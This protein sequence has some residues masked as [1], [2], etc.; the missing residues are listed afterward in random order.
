MTRPA[1]PAAAPTHLLSRP[2]ATLAA[3]VGALVGGL[4]GATGL[5]VVAGL[6]GGAV[7]GL[8]ALVTAVASVGAVRVLTAGARR[9]RYQ[10]RLA[11]RLA[12]GLADQERA[13]AAA[14]RNLEFQIAK[15]TS[16]RLRIAVA[17]ADRADDPAA[18]QRLKRVLRT[19]DTALEA[20]HLAVASLDAAAYEIEL[21]RWLCQLDALGEGVHDLGQVRQ[22]LVEAGVLEA[23][24][25]RVTDNLAALGDR[26]P[27]GDLVDRWTA[28]LAA[29]AEV[30]EALRTEEER[31]LALLV[32]DAVR[33]IQPIAGGGARPRLAL[34]APAA[35]LG[36]GAGV[37]M[38]SRLA[39][40]RDAVARCVDEE[41]RL[42]AEIDAL[43]E[44][45]RL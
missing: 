6:V 20:R 5:G 31:L 11:R 35:L 33:E 30:R 22:R 8:G 12:S 15:L 27:A 7:V 38:P 34:P 16:V 45:D 10:R 24:A 9:R 43:V 1:G 26:A 4:A 13:S 42:R 2:G 17:I 28:G 23:I 25:R 36:P 3:G 21:A 29:L 44:V 19:V 41:Q 18:Q 32:E 40:V 39:G 14:R 37:T